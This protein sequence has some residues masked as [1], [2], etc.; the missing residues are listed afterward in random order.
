[1]WIR[2]V[3]HLDAWESRQ[4]HLLIL[5]MTYFEFKFSTHCTRLDECTCSRSYTPWRCVRVQ[6]V[7][8]LYLKL[9]N[10]FV[11]LSPRS[12]SNSFELAAY[13]RL[14]CV[15]N[16]M[17]TCVFTRMYLCALSVF[18]CFYICNHLK[19]RHNTHTSLHTHSMPSLSTFFYNSVEGEGRGTFSLQHAYNT[20][21]PRK[22]YMLY[23]YMYTLEHT[24]ITCM[25]INMHTFWNISTFMQI[26]DICG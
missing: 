19:Q 16:Q 9:L 6:C 15:F 18:V 20:I 22:W 3:T 14:P 24:S 7:G 25:D 26:S 12:K 4:G 8:H 21:T 2:H 5:S 1:M 10:A 17:C 23:A 13:T 11:I